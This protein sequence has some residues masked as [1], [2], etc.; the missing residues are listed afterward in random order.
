MFR[1]LETETSI[2]ENL[3]YFNQILIPSKTIVRVVGK[4]PIAEPSNHRK[5]ALRGLCFEFR[6]PSGAKIDASKYPS[7]GHLGTA[8]EGLPYRY[9]SV[10][11]DMI[12]LSS[13]NK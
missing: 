12:N 1:G 7:D 13:L 5:M 3:F 8:A 2:E 9:I 10:E 4:Q 6:C 11:H